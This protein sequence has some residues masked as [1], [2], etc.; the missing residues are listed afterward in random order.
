MRKAL[1]GAGW[2]S[3]DYGDFLGLTDGERKLVEIRVSIALRVRQL[4]RDLGLTQTQLAALSGTTQAR[5]ADIEAGG[6]GVS[7]DL[8]LRAYFAAGGSSAGIGRPPRHRAT[9][10]DDASPVV[11]VKAAKAK[12]MKIK[13]AKARPAK[14]QTS[15]SV[16]AKPSRDK[17]PR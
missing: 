3:G 5:I 17:V 13:A 7:T 2:R 9:R 10:V 8:M 14:G 15:R 6:V 4:R 16:A 1:E 12:P 11:R